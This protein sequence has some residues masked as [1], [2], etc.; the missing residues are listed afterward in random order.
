MSSDINKKCVQYVT[1]QGTEPYLGPEDL[2]TVDMY[3]L[4]QSGDQLNGGFFTCKPILIVIGKVF[5]N[6]HSES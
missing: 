5:P 1:Q 3:S 2:Y 4:G 6:T